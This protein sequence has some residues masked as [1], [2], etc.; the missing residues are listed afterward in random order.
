MK[1]INVVV[2]T[3]KMKGDVRVSHTSDQS[4]ACTFRLLVRKPVSERPEIRTTVV[5]SAYG[6]SLVRTCRQFGRDGAS[7]LVQGELMNA[8]L[9]G[10]VVRAFTITFP[11]WP[12]S[13][14][15]HG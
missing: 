10:P 13:R 3:G 1:D 9:P 12:G 11:E 6:E 2:V 8:P 14:E 15:N 5:V 7:V 4:P